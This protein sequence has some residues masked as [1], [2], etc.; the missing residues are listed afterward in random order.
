VL[1]VL[2]RELIAGRPSRQPLHSRRVK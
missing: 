1:G 2:V